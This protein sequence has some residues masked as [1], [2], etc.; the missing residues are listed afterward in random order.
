MGIPLRAGR[1][2]D[3]R[4]R[5]DS[6]PVIA[7]DDVLAQQ[8][9]H[10]SSPQA[11]IGRQLWIPPMDS[12]P[13]RIVGV[14]GH[15]RHWGLGGDDQSPVRAQIYYPFSQLPDSLVHRWSDLMSIAVRTRVEPFSLLP[16]L[17]R[18]VAGA[19]GDQVLY[20]ER[21]MEQLASGSLARQRF[22]ML[23]FGIFAGLALVLASIGIYGVLAYLTSQRT[24]EVGVR[25]ALG[26]S[27]GNVLGI[28]LRHSAGM[29]AGGVIVGVAGALAAGRL[30]ERFVSGMNAA[31]P[32]TVVGMVSILAAAAL[33]ASFLPARRASRIDPMSALRQ[34]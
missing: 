19:G 31:D 26:A 20:E 16:A 15:V 9:F 22:L 21:T 23:L 1:F 27:T 25:M 29:I 11:V 33:L 12:R 34:E 32:A 10:T 18:A 6:E 5:P 28:V 17:R 7:I 8:A 24:Q 3:T 13:V 4:D 14:V 30:L 2:F